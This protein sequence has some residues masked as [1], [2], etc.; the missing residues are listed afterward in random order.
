[1][2]LT[3]S[4]ASVIK[5]GDRIVDDMGLD[6]RTAKALKKLWRQH[7]PH[8]VGSAEVI[9][10]LDRMADRMGVDGGFNE[11]ILKQ[12]MALFRWGKKKGLFECDTPDEVAAVIFCYTAI[13]FERWDVFNTDLRTFGE[14][15]RV[16]WLF[17]D[18][19][20]AMWR[21]KFQDETEA[22]ALVRELVYK[23][24]PHPNSIPI[25]ITKAQELLVWAISHPDHPFL[26]SLAPA[27]VYAVLPHSLFDIT[28]EDVARAGGV[29]V[30]TIKNCLEWVRNAL[31]E[32]DTHVLVDLLRDRGIANPQ[33][34]RHICE[35]PRVHFVSALIGGRI[36]GKHHSHFVSALKRCGRARCPYCGETYPPESPKDGK[37][38]IKVI[39]EHDLSYDET[40]KQAVKK[41]LCGHSVEAFAAATI[42]FASREFG[43][44]RDMGEI[45]RESGVDLCR[46]ERKYRKIVSMLADEELKLPAVVVAHC[47]HDISEK[48]EEIYGLRLSDEI[49]FE[50]VT[51]LGQKKALSRKEALKQ[52]AVVVWDV[53]RKREARITRREIARAVKL[54]RVSFYRSTSDGAL[55]LFPLKK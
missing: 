50:A 49:R 15:P 7:V 18:V 6:A 16:L 11:K 55:P 1:M 9:D 31:R 19:Y 37:T 22:D 29:S 14:D 10:A 4:S 34:G 26:K 52:A 43:L 35:N 21:Q 39:E 28:I 44:E 33:I 23:I 48:L 51:T 38:L 30:R 41:S 53:C 17:S 54:S 8:A 36:C 46:L 13:P 25:V 32:G 20:D 45:A 47:V 42:H 27:C 3:I 2:G 12:A 24:K 5:A 40:A